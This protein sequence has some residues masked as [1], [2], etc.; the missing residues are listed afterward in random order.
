MSKLTKRI[1]K[2]CHNKEKISIWQI[3]KKIHFSNE[4][5]KTN[6][7]GTLWRVSSK[8]KLFLRLCFFCYGFVYVLF[9]LWYLEHMT[10]DANG[11]I[12]I[13]L[14]NL[15]ISI[16]PLIVIEIILLFTVKIECKK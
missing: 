16:I 12:L 13:V 4:Y 9:Y 15:F 3:W 14:L 1:C 2:C 10:I 8:Y 7:D 5:T 11:R 6:N